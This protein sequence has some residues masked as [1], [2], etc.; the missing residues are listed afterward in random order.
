MGLWTY[1]EIAIGTIVSCT[2]VLPKVF[3][4][5]LPRI[6]H[7]TF[8]ASSKSGKPGGDPRPKPPSSQQQQSPA[9]V[10]AA[11]KPRSSSLTESAKKLVS[12]GS[13]RGEGE[14]GG[15]E[16]VCWNDAY[17]PAFDV[18]GRDGCYLV[19]DGD[20]NDDNDNDDAVSSV[21]APETAK[22]TATRREDLESGHDDSV[23]GGR[24]SIPRR[25]FDC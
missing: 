3:R 17:H 21:L 23:F 11:G 18:Q 15:V 16:E 25:R 9:V 24:A 1:A 8:A 22:G 20:D 13:E 7:A 19:P 2:P 4:H 12:R 5:F 6:I 14:K 10:V